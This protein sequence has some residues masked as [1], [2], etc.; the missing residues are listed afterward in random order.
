MIDQ[1]YLIQAD[2]LLQVIP[3]IAKE[4]TLALKGGTAINL[5]L[6]EMPRLSV[7]IDLTYLPFVNR[8]TAL[9]NISDSLGRIRERITGSIPG[10]AVT[11]HIIEGND[12]KL[13]VQSKNALIKIEVNTTTRGHLHPVKLL[14]ANET[15]QERFKKF[16]AI[17]VV[18]DAE[19]YGGKICAALDRQHPRDLFDVFLLF[20]ESGYNEDIKYGFI[21]ALVSHMRTIHE[22]LHPHLLDQRSAFDKQFQG[23]SDIPFSYEDFETTREKLIETV[24]SSLSDSDRS[25]LLSFKRGNPD[26]DLF[27]Y[28]KLKDMPAAQWKL[29]N[30]QNL[31]KS[32]PGKH[33]ELFSKLETFLSKGA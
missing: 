30:L 6:R 21:Q 22:V 19:L 33:K 16:A 17:Q 18:S 29:L 27:P 5:F 25:F 11:N 10:A 32:N 23:M 14:Q 4:K 28:T 8:E 31:I 7:D 20:Q 2:L 12:V 9:T 13:F 15:V 24:N 3:H 1:S 26:W